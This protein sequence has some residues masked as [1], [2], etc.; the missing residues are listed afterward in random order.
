MQKIILKLRNS[1]RNGNIGLSCISVW[2]GTGLYYCQQIVASPSSKRFV[3]ALRIVFSYCT[4]SEFILP[5]VLRPAPLCIGSPV[6]MGDFGGLIPPNKVPI[7]PNWSMK[8]CKLGEFCQ[9]LNANPPCTNA[10][11]PYWRLSGDVSVYMTSKH[12][13]E[14]VHDYSFNSTHTCP[15]TS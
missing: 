13:T 5:G 15:A 14:L 1:R 4:L 3:K 11:A 9:F 7:P 10:K 2:D 12:L 8:H 6:A